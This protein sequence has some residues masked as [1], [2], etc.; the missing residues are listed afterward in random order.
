G[1]SAVADHGVAEQA[2]QCAHRRQC[3]CGGRAKGG[4]GPIM[5]WAA[6]Q[7]DFQKCLTDAQAVGGM[8]LTVADA[9]KGIT[10]CQALI[11]PWTPQITIAPIT[12]TNHTALDAQFGRSGAYERFQ[13]PLVLS[14]ASFSLPFG[15]TAAAFSHPK[16]GLQ[17][18]GIEI[19]RVSVTSNHGTFTG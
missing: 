17:I 18:D 16:Y 2:R 13:R 15:T 19:S 6:V 11:A 10:D 3:E 12:T 7:A 1:R 14:T 5:S 8:P 4:D 9:Q